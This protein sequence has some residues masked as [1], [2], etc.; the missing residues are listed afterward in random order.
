MV[1]RGRGGRGTGGNLFIRI[2]HGAPIQAPTLF[3][4]LAIRA[5]IGLQVLGWVRTT[6]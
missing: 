4:D 3:G 2:V 6:E 1:A 5:G